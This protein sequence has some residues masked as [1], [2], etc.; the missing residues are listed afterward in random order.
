MVLQVAWLTQSFG[1]SLLC[2]PMR[3]NENE[4]KEVHVFHDH[5]S[6]VNCISWAS[7]ELML[8]LDFLLMG[9]ISILIARSDGGWDMTRIG[10]AHSGG[11]TSVSWAPAVAP[12]PMPR[13]MESKRTMTVQK[14]AIGNGAQVVHDV[15]IDYCGQHLASASSDT[16]VKIIALSSNS[17]LKTLATLLGHQ[18]PVLQVAW[19]HPKFGSILASCSYEGRVIIWKEVNQNEWAPA[20]VFYEHKSFVIS[21]ARHELGLCLACGSP[22]GSITVLIS[23][24]DGGWDT[25]RIEQAHSHGVTSLIVASSHGSQGYAWVLNLGCSILFLNWLL[26]SLIIL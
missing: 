2:V 21:W 15:N 23:W 6:L 19:P 7:H 3:G 16:M 24:S 14:M 11:V 10:Q 1:R 9:V 13:I 8:C 22:D 12:G 4:W 26:G 17:T 20:R 18:G 5:R 25:S